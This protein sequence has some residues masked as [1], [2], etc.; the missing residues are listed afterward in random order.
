MD[1]A[2]ERDIK[3]RRSALNCSLSIHITAFETVSDIAFVGTVFSLGIAVGRKRLSAAGTDKGIHRP[4]LNLF[5]M[6]MPPLHSAFITA[7]HTGFH[8]LRLLQEFPA[9]PTFRNLLLCG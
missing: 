6:F 9:L 2:T 7:E 4:L 8:A 3:Y 5:R 1:F